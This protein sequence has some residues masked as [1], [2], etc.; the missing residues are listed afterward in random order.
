MQ[1]LQMVLSEAEGKLILAAGVWFSGKVLRVGMWVTGYELS[2]LD[3]ACRQN[4]LEL[5]SLEIKPKCAQ[6]FI[7]IAWYRPPKHDIS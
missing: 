1:N 3:V 6:S 7:L 4:G 2:T 5:I